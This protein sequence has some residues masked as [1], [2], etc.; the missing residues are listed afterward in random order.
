MTLRITGVVVD[1]PTNAR[2]PEE[3]RAAVKDRLDLSL[4]DFRVAALRARASENHQPFYEVS[5]FIDVCRR[6]GVSLS[7][8]G[9]KPQKGDRR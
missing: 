2:Y 3:F 1:L 5:T 9:Y 4:V 8:S 7:P 6:L